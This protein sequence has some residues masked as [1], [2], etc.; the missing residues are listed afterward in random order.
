MR[1][2]YRRGGGDTLVEFLFSVTPLPCDEHR[3]LLSPR[4]VLNVGESSI[5]RGILVGVV[6][7]RVHEVLGSIENH[8]A[9]FPRVHIGGIEAV[10]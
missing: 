5:D 2:V 10:P 4:D 7:A 9:V 8:G 1:R 6:V 3:S